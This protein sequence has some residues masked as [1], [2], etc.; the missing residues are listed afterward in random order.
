MRTSLIPI[1]LLAMSI[2]IP[3]ATC[4]GQQPVAPPISG[5]ENENDQLCTIAGA[6]L[7]ANTGEPLKKAHVDL[8]R[9]GDES[10]EHPF[11]ASSDA[12]GHFSIDKIPA[13]RYDL[14]VGR[15]NYLDTQYGQDQ[16]DKPGAILSLA[17]G[18]KITDLLF[19]LHR[20]AVIT[21]RILDEDGEPVR[22]AAVTAVA[23]TTVRGKIRLEPSESE[24]TNDLGTYR[25]FDLAPGHYSIL[26]N[27]PRMPPWREPVEQDV[28]LP[29]YYPGT[30]DSARAST[31]EVKS[32]D[33]LTGIDFVLA[34]KPPARTYKIHGH[35]LNSLTE[36]PDVNLIVMLAPRGNRD[37]ESSAEPQQANL[38]RKTGDF[39]IKDVVPGEYVVAAIS[40]GTGN[41]HT[42][43]Q[44]VDVITSDI[45]GVSLV[46]TRG[47]DILVR[48]TLEGKAAA[49]ANVTVGLNPSMDDATS[50]F[51]EVRRSVARPDG[52]FV[53]KEVGDGSYS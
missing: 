30:T 13:G 23:H 42:A 19:R 26:A 22:G 53:L 7:S 3:P 17:P 9:R 10:D 48:V 28:Y 38:D 25:I 5:N 49:S 43:V 52:S 46:L 41:N 45:D 24:N 35:V 31:L 12:S 11:I 50:D 2:F 39:E 44:S 20:T 36:Y 18:Q 14:R 1:A 16:P 32:G 40:F 51:V 33:E 47:I 34:P 21:G 37:A 6:V 4:R 27:P 15:T 29:T 8:H